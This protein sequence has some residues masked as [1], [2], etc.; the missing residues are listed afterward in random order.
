[1]AKPIDVTDSSFQ[2]EVLEA[3]VPVLVDFWGVRC[4][5]CKA[6]SQMVEELAEEFDGRVKF[7][8]PDVEPNWKTAADFQVRSLPTLLLFKEGK[9]VGKVVGEVDKSALKNGMEKAIS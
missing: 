7:A 3:A 8:K 6:V 9:P 4:V 2:A 1:M 5:P